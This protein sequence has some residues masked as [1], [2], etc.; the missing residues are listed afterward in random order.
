YDGQTIVLGGLIS[1]RYEKRENKVPLLGDMPL[2]GA[3]F[4]Q[5]KEQTAKTELLIVLTP[6]VIDSPAECRRVDDIT[7]IE[8]DRL[9]VPESVKESIRRSV[10][11]GTG[12]LYDAQGHKIQIEAPDAPAPPPVIPPDKTHP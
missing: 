1:D 12:G 6:H 8:V 4:R 3:L 5:S 10:I 9:S 2:L 7:S 11:D